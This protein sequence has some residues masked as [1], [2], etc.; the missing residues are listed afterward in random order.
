MVGMTRAIPLLLLACSSPGGDKSGGGVGDSAPPT[1]VPGTP[2]PEVCNGLDDDLDGVVDVGPDG[3]VCEAS[4]DVI[5]PVDLLMLVDNS[6]AMAQEQIRLQETALE[7]LEALDARGLDFQVGVITTDMVDPYHQ[8]R[9]LQANSARWVT[10]TSEVATY[11]SMVVP[12]TA[13][14]ATEKGRDAIHAALVQ[15]AAPGEHNEG[16]VRADADLGV[17][18]VVD[19]SD[20]ST[21][22]DRVTMRDTLATYKAADASVSV[23]AFVVPPEGCSTGSTPG[24]DYLW[25]STELGGIQHDI[26]DT[27]NFGTALDAVAGYHEVPESDFQ[28]SVNA[29]PAWL[30]ATVDDAGTVTEYVASELQWDAATSTVG[31]PVPAPGG[32]VVTVAYGPTL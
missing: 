19:E 20:F 9:L 22:V 3:G 23:H 27:E 5:R 17:V 11:E 10:S 1:S 31:L 16:F 26:C 29:D 15:H 13:G 4:F 2:S 6:C 18:V 21:D 24:D 30:S 7:F 28:L 25:L 32:S 8:G 12:G 14:A